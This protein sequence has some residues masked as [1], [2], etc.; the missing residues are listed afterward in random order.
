[1][2][3]ASRVGAWRSVRWV[4][5]RPYAGPTAALMLLAAVGRRRFASAFF[6]WMTRR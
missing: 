5:P 6:W 4:T 1:M 2:P 3:Q